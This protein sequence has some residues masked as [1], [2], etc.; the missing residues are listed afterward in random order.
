MF[1]AWIAEVPGS[2]P[3]LLQMTHLNPISQ[4]PSEQ[5]SGPELP[6]PS[7]SVGTIRALPMPVRKYDSTNQIVSIFGLW[8]PRGG[9]FFLSLMTGDEYDHVE[10]AGFPFSEKKIRYEMVQFGAYSGLP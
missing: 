2:D 7:T 5:I 9:S 6:D 3:P 1:C 4:H 8:L 10:C